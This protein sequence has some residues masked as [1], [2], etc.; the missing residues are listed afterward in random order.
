[1]KNSYNH[2]LT[3]VTSPI[4]VGNGTTFQFSVTFNTKPVEDVGLVEY[5]K[6]INFER[7]KS[8][9]LNATFTD[10][11]IKDIISD[12]EKQRSVLQTT[13]VSVTKFYTNGSMMLSY[14]KWWMESY[15]TSR[16]D[17][18]CLQT[19]SDNLNPRTTLHTVIDPIDREMQRII[20]NY[21][22]NYSQTQQQPSMNSATN[23]TNFK[24]N[25][26]H[27]VPTS[28]QTILNVTTKIITSI[29]VTSSHTARINTSKVIPTVAE[30]PFATTI[31]IISIFCIIWISKS[32]RF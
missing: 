21:N 5:N 32:R 11:M 23:F 26:T 29:N 19:I 30:F 4:L 1:M 9:I 3:S 16:L 6:A 13:G 28:H 15:V 17:Q 2:P 18:D 20:S 27:L 25:R 24:L 7:A 12:V 10:K 22:L 8:M 31:L 14:S